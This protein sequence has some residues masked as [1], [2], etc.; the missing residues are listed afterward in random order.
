[1]IVEWMSQQLA[2]AENTRMKYSRSDFKFRSQANHMAK[3]LTIK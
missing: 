1:M 3:I 2:S